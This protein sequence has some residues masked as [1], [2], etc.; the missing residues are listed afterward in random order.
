MQAVGQVC[1]YGYLRWGKGVLLG[2]RCGIILFLTCAGKQE[3]RGDDEND[4]LSH[5]Q[6]G[7]VS[8]KCNKIFNLEVLVQAGGKKIQ[9]IKSMVRLSL[10]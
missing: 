8:H 4:I 2:C 9:W 5:R 6:T 10:G 1:Q 3:Q 7:V